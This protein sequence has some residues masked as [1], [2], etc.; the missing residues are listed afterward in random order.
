VTHH[1]GD[2]A[3]VTSEQARKYLEI[4]L[5]KIMP[6]PESVVGEITLEQMFKDVTYEMLKD[7]EFQRKVREAYPLL[8]WP[9]GPM[10][11]YEA[12]P[13]KGRLPKL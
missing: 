9:E 4:E 3:V 1:A 6:N 8:D 5:D 10:T 7:D 11:E 2:I 13:G 12:A